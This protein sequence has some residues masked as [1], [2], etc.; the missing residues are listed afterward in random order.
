MPKR[1]AAL[2][3]PNPRAIADDIW[4]KLVGAGLNLT[5]N[6]LPRREPAHLGFTRL[7]AC[8]LEL[9]RAIALVWLFADLRKNEI[10]RLRLG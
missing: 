7:H 9:C 1:L 3:G 5:A 4:A 10:L 8:F 6:D 2:I